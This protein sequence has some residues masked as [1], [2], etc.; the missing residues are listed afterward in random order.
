VIP[1]FLL[2]APPRQVSW[3]LGRWRVF[4]LSPLGMFHTGCGV[5]A[6]V[7]GA[8]IFLATKGTG[9]HVRAGWAY[10]ASMACLNG[11]ALGLYHLT[12][13]FNVFHALALFSLA[14]VAGGVIQVLGRRRWP[15]WMWRHY[16]YMAW[17]YVGLLAAT[18]NEAFVRVPALQRL[19]VGGLA[20]LPLLGTAAVVVL[21]GAV[22]FGMRRRVLARYSRAAEEGAAP[23]RPR[24]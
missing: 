22:I 11:S 2:P 8:G 24:D 15:K 23:A 4:Q 12:G 10:V 7:L 16:Q 20:P 6:L 18:C 13:G 1:G 3:S 9:A 5:L 17:S 14:M 21:S 19:A